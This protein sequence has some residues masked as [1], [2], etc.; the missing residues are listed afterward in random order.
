MDLKFCGSLQ[1]CFWLGFLLLQLFL[2]GSGHSICV[3]WGNLSVLVMLGPCSACFAPSPLFCAIIQATVRQTTSVCDSTVMGNLPRSLW[4]TANE[5]GGLQSPAG[6]MLISCVATFLGQ[7]EMRP[8]MTPKAGAKTHWSHSMYLNQP[9][10]SRRSGQALGQA[11]QG[12]VS[13]F[14][15]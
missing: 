4:V 12:A 11:A 3:P 15:P 1:Q 5:P 7:N 9:S 2:L 10:F 6:W 13:L 8:K 14:Q